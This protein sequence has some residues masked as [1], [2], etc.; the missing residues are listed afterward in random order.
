MDN[1]ANIAN[2]QNIQQR[3]NDSSSVVGT[4]NRNFNPIFVIPA[5]WTLLS[6]T[7][8]QMQAVLQQYT[9]CPEPPSPHKFLKKT[10]V[11]QETHSSVPEGQHFAHF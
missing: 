4:E 9:F 7:I 8:V 1:I 2:I 5:L 11:V 3:S 6:P 10:I